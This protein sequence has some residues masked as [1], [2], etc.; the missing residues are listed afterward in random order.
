MV[1]TE[2]AYSKSKEIINNRFLTLA[3]YHMRPG[4]TEP[5]HYHNGV[6]FVYVLDGNCQTHEKGQLYQ[7]DRGQVHE[8][9]NKSP[10]EVVFVC[11]SIPQDTPANT[12]YV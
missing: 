6:E 11:L 4:G 9:I 10:N 2:P 8:V 1:E 5:K 7:Y 12:V 3:V